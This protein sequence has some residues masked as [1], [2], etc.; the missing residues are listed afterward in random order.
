MNS[1]AFIEGRRIAMLRLAP[2]LNPHEDG[3][4]ES[5][6]WFRGWQDGLQ[7]LISRQRRAPSLEAVDGMEARTRAAKGV[8]HSTP[9]LVE[10]SA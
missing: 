7:F 1:P 2:A 5:V 10:G 4:T 9:L 8:A 6:E 3:T